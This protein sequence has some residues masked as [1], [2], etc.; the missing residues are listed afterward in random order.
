MH[1]IL[2][3]AALALALVGGAAGIGY[4]QSVTFS[5]GNVGIGY[6]DGYWDRDHAW[7]EWQRDADRDAYRRS[8]NAEYHEWRHDRDKDMG[9]H[10]RHY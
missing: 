6:S 4:A 3:T 7:H 9:W 5:T 2:K 10:E 1:G 8:R